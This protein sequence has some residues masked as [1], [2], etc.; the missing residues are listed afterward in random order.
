MKIK[1]LFLLSCGL[2]FIWSCKN[3][4]VFEGNHDPEV[5]KTYRNNSTPESKMDSL[6]S[7]NFITKQKLTE[8]YELMSLYAV[9]QDDSLMS[10]I[11][12]PQI[13]SYF[14]PQDS[15]NIPRLLYE[16]DSLKVNYIEITGLDTSKRD[17]LISDS[18]RSVDYWV[19]YYN[20]DKKLIDSLHKSTKYVL[21]KEPK[22]F[23]HEFIFYFENLD[24]AQETNDTISSGVMQ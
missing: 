7:V 14:Q 21:K 12:Y 10:D 16:M 6:A 4:P 24:I 20:K 8:I 3:E 5:I 19:R 23:K 13:Q 22:K 11:L 2:I 1:S 9:N 15:L 17:S 18:I